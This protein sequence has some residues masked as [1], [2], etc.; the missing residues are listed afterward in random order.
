[1]HHA[2]TKTDQEITEFPNHVSPLRDTSGS[3]DAYQWD[4]HVLNIKN[5]SDEEPSDVE[6]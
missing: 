4:Y 2:E 1:M 6:L 3:R 5:Q